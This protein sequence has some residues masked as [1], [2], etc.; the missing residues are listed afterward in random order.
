MSL[1]VL[2]VWC[3]IPIEPTIP[4]IQPRANT[5]YWT[6]SGGYRIAF[7]HVASA[8]PTGKP[9]I[10]FLHGGPGAYV[11]SSAISVF[12]QLV[13]LGHDVYLYDQVGSGLSDRLPRPKDISFLG[14]VR[15][16]H[17]IVTTH[18]G[19]PKVI[20]IGH[21]YGG[22]LAT[23]FVA[24]Y[25]ELVDRV[26]LSSPGI[27]QPT[28]FTEDGQW[29]NETKYVPPPSIK[30]VDID[31]VRTDGIR[32]WPLRVFAS[33]AVG[34]AF[35]A[36]LMSDAEADGILNTL[37]ASHITRNVVCDPSHVLPEEGGAGFYAYAWGNWYG[38][39][40]DPRPAIR[41]VTAPVVV[42]QGACDY[43]PYAA[44][45]E[46]VD[47][48]QNARY[49]FVEGAGHVI[50]W[51]RPVEYSEEIVRFLVQDEASDSST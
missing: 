33:V 4:P 18:L 1:T 7:T 30:F 29:T 14:H 12:G 31:F 35:N 44:T 28:Q 34:W 20:L 25:P 37:A 48:M 38:D 16:I 17:E 40:D 6:M 27:I 23:Q 3:L 15:D 24:T 41:K 21:S 49:V 50:W 11:H 43:I 45:Y 39:L 42:L 19:A 51:D 13:E 47:L 9:P 10:M 26:V 5:Q 46:Y 8:R 2:V 36:K 22:K 32:F